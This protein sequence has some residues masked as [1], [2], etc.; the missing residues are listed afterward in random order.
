MAPL[1]IILLIVSLVEAAGIIAIIAGRKIK[2]NLNRS[3]CSLAR[4]Q[5]HSAIE[6]LSKLD[7]TLDGITKS[8]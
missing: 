2:K 7:K 6:S 3:E 5:I 1:S 8:K 4:V